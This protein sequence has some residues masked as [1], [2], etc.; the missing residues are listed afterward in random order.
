MGANAASVTGQGPSTSDALAVAGSPEASR[1]TSR[2]LVTG[3]AGFIGSHVSEALLLAGCSVTGLDNFDD[4]YD[5]RL[6]RANIEALPSERF[7]L[8]DGDIRDPAALESA[9]AG[10]PFDAVVHLA[11]RAGVRTSI[12]NP[13]LYE[14][15]NVAGTLALL[16]AARRAPGTHFIFGSSSSVY[17]S[18]TPPPFSEDAVADR[19]SSPYAATKRSGELA[20]HTYYHNYGMPVTCLRFFT[21]YGPRQRPEMAIH[22]FTRTIDEGRPVTIFGDGQSVRDYTYVA[23]IVA[24]ILGA[25]HN[26][27]GFRVFNLGSSHTT[28]LRDLVEMI[29]SL[30]G[31]PLLTERLPDQPGDVPLTHANITRANT[32]FGYEP[33]TTIAAGLTQFVAWYRLSRDQ[34][35]TAPSAVDV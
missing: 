17:G 4:Y 1:D 16:E 10:G 31:R 13:L 34:G 14:S 19:P 24:G 11:A 7:Q 3:A 26:P 18:S 8:V 23:D 15:I 5:P 28:T 20:A 9:F 27:G 12:A 25:M 22:L 33:K 30:L 6:K 35:V 29:A 21:V 2:V 32:T